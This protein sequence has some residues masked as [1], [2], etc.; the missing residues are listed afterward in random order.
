MRLLATSLLFSF[1]SGEGGWGYRTGLMEEEEDDKEV[2][3]RWTWWSGY[4]GPNGVE[5]GRALMEGRYRSL[6]DI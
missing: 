3:K 6:G 1:S 2:R 5:E 4:L